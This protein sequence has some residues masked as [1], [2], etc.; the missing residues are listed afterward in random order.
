MHSL[1][2]NNINSFFE[3]DKKDGISCVICIEGQ[4]EK[5]TEYAHPKAQKEA[6]ILANKLAEQNTNVHITD[7]VDY[8]M[9]FYRRE[10]TKIYNL[11]LKK[12]ANNYYYSLLEKSYGNKEICSYHQESQY[13]NFKKKCHKC[14]NYFDNKVPNPCSSCENK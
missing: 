12:Y 9:L 11:L 14:N 5:F 6:H 10:Y 7:Y 2:Y 1:N 8:Y 13:S 3:N 4:N